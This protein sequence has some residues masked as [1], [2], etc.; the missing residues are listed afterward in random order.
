[1]CRD[2][3]QSYSL[4]LPEPGPDAVLRRVSRRSASESAASQGPSQ[5]TLS[6]D[7]LWSA[8]LTS[9][10]ERRATERW[11]LAPARQNRHRQQKRSIRSIFFFCLFLQITYLLQ[12]QFSQLRIKNHFQ[13]PKSYLLLFFPGIQIHEQK[14]AALIRGKRNKTKQNKNNETLDV[15]FSLSFWGFLNTSAK[16]ILNS[17]TSLMVLASGRGFG[18]VREQTAPCVSYVST[19]GCIDLRCFFCFLQIRCSRPG[20]LYQGWK[21][22]QHNVKSGKKKKKK[23]KALLLNSCD[24]FRGVKANNDLKR[25]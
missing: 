3:H 10:G 16:K 17:E 25:H 8:T 9:S 22:R 6:V 13:I 1:M 20:K 19:L 2:H 11:D 18:H 12:R 23:E 15:T 5:E 21:V 14:I 7:F 4:T 24:V